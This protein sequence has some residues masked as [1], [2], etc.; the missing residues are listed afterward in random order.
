MTAKAIH[1]VGGL[2]EDVCVRATVLDGLRAG[3][4][5]HLLADATRPVE[6]SADARACDEMD[7]ADAVIE[8]GR[9]VAL[10]VAP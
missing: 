10:P 5:V 1:F 8:H 9:G 3:F 2:A 4:E 7:R 6:A